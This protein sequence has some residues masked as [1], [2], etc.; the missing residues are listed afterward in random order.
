M[1][2]MGSMMTTDY[3]NFEPNCQNDFVLD[4]ILINLL[5]CNTQYD[6]DGKIRWAQA[7]WD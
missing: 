1:M 4:Y 2:A 5:V 7:I 3:V 6:Y